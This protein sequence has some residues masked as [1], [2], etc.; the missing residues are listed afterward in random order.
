MVAPKKT[1]LQFL[2]SRL[3]VSI[4]W[5]VSRFGSPA[6]SL[7]CELL[8]NSPMNFLSAEVTESHFV[9]LV[10]LR[11][12]KSPIYNSRQRPSRRGKMCHMQLLEEILGE[13]APLPSSV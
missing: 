11:N 2:L 8:V 10:S 12:T 5:P 6:F 7:F 4:H 9:L 1:G 13:R 3:R